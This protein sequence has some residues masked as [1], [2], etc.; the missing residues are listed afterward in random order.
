MGNL[1]GWLTDAIATEQPCWFPGLADE[2]IASF[3]GGTTSDPATY[4][5][6]DWLGLTSATLSVPIPGVATMKL[7]PFPAHYADRFLAPSFA[8]ASQTAPRA[9]AVALKR[10]EASGAGCAV[11]RLIRSVHCIKALGPGYDCS[12][13]EPSLP[14][15][16]FVSVPCA[17]PDGELRL[18]E[19]LLHEAMHLQLTLIERHVALTHADAGDGYSPWQQQQRPLLGLIHGLYVF[20]AIHCWLTTLTADDTISDS[21][22][23][24]AHRR[25]RNIDEEIAQVT[26]LAS[27]PGLTSFGSA[28]A[29]WLLGATGRSLNH[30][31]DQLPYHAGVSSGR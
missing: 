6:A 11:T 13:S 31:S 10:L 3:W 18:A 16:A 17:E 29:A 23:A 26:A 4:T 15:S 12:H 27:A 9:I 22:R 7:E 2:L 21:D 5:T 1:E 24:Y 30:A 14:F 28:F 19:S 8:A 25:L 20:T